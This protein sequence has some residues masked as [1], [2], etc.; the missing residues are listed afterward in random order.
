M[1]LTLVLT[2]FLYEFYNLQ[3]EMFLFLVLLEISI[4]AKK[5]IT[6]ELINN[7]L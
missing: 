3:Y 2:H 4:S 7:R 1:L 6:I 5:M